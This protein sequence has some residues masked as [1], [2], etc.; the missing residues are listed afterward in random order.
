MHIPDEYTERSELPTSFE[1]WESLLGRLRQVERG[2]VSML[3]SYDLPH[4]HGHIHAADGISSSYRRSYDELYAAHDPWAARVRDLALPGTVWKGDQILS[5]MERIKS[6]YYN[7]WLKPQGI[8]HVIR[9]VLHREHEEILFVD[10]GRRSDAGGYH[11]KDVD[12]FRS[13]LPKLQRGANL[14][15]VIDGLRRRSEAALRALDMIPIGM[16]VIGL[17]DHPVI[18]NRYA[19]DLLSNLRSTSENLLSRFQLQSDKADCLPETTR[20]RSVHQRA[21]ISRTTAMDMTHPISIP[22]PDGLRPLSA[23]VVHLS[24]A[25]DNCAEDGL[26]HLVLISD[27]DHGI[28]LNRERLQRIYGLTPAEARLAAL[29]VEGKRLRTAAADLEISFE[30]ARTHLKRIFSKTNSES[31]ADLVRLLLNLANQITSST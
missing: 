6:R 8:A 13:L 21:P 18:V 5:N 4:R 23:V 17:E 9:G 20:K 16:L 19:R 22:R 12:T 11:Q 2:T 15:L 26:S 14:R 29:L 27:P 24:M 1:S 7:E 25:T 28:A 30:T 10:V 3:V 31:Q